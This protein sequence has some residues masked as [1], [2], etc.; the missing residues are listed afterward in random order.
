MNALRIAFMGTPD[1][2]VPS[3]AALVEAGHDVAVVYTQPPRPAGRGQKARVSPV[4]SWAEAHGL[5]VRS[6]RTLRDGPEQASFAGL[7]LDAA[8]VAAYGLIL[9]V[10]VLAAPRLGCLNVHASLLP[11]WRGAAP[12]QR[13][14][15]AGDRRT[16]ISIMLM[17]QG[18]DTGP[19][20]LTESVQIGKTMTAGDLHDRLARIGARLIVEGLRGYAAGEIS[21]RPQDDDKATYASKIDK[22]EARID[23]TEAA[24]GIDRRVRAFV[25]WPGAWFELGSERVKVLAAKV[26]DGVGVA[27]EVLDDRLLVACGE[28]AVR[29]TRLQREGRRPM[30]AETFLRGQLLTKGTV[31]S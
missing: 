3:L 13:A 11:R 9:P 6:P 28:N 12:I 26:E 14:I 24:V 16:G 29:L 30:D 22:S 25:P 18:L 7:G 8:V 31:L 19:V 21:P 15:L 23:W 1:F 10:P 17:G 2:A 4:Q 20:L 27:G 5:P